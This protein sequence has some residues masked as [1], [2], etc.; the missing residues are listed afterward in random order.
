V[1]FDGDSFLVDHARASAAAS[2]SWSSEE[3]IREAHKWKAWL[4]D[5][6][7]PAMRQMRDR[8]AA[9]K[10]DDEQWL[11]RWELWQAE[12]NN[13]RFIEGTPKAEEARD[14][15][16]PDFQCQKPENLL[17][18]E[19]RQPREESWSKQRRLEAIQKEAKQ[20]QA[21][22]REILPGNQIKL[23]YA[24]KQAA[25]YQKAHEVAR[26]DAECLCPGG[27]FT[28]STGVEAFGSDLK[29][30]IEELTR[31]VEESQ[32]EVKLMREWIV[33]L[34]DGTEKARQAAQE[35]IGGRQQ[36]V[37]TCMEQIRGVTLALETYELK[38]DEKELF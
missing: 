2:A 10:T 31:Y 16:C 3:P 13:R 38:G 18:W 15:A 11:A 26:L 35:V 17:L 37:K 27:S 14:Y 36:H 5:E 24:E 1:D 34:P 30:R 32:Q 8:L 21:S 4:Q 29:A 7:G 25:V 6:D 28:V 9:A 19:V 23:R 33:Q 22:E 12:Q 20:L